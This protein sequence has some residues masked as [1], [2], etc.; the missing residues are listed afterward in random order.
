M[1]NSQ[2]GRLRQAKYSIFFFSRPLYVRDGFFVGARMTVDYHVIG[3]HELPVDYDVLVGASEKCLKGKVNGWVEIE[4]IN[5]T[6]ASTT[7]RLWQKQLGEL[8]T[9]EIRKLRDRASQV[10]ISAVNSALFSA[11]WEKWAREQCKGLDKKNWTKKYLELQKAE[12]HRRKE[13]HARQRDHL[14]KVIEVYFRLLEEERI[15]ADTQ[16]VGAGEGE[17]HGNKLRPD[18]ESAMID[19]TTFDAKDGR[20]LYRDFS[21]DK[22]R[23]FLKAIP[24]ISGKLRGGERLRSSRI[25]TEK[26][27]SQSMVSN[28]FRVLYTWGLRTVDG[29]PLPYNPRNSTK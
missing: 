10:A 29:I 14:D 13:L 18:I 12:N 7:Y 19:R 26:Y 5:E 25:A 9:I 15:W 27:V 6:I 28:H 23:E 20:K 2:T 11:E 24:D 1:V 16:A 4:K 22:A 17:K 8:G 21:Q 3:T